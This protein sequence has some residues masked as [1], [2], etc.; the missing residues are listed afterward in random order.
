MYPV[1]FKRLIISA[2]ILCSLLII[3]NMAHA[4]T[5][6]DDF[7][8]QIR[9]RLEASGI[10]VSIVIGDELIYASEALPLF[11]ER[12]GYLP[13]WISE[14]KIKKETD[15]LISAIDGAA[16]E[17]LDPR[18]YHITGIRS[19]LKSLRSRMK[20]EKAEKEKKLLE[21]ELLC[22]DAFLIYS[23]HLLRGK[24]NPRSID[25]E[26]HANLREMD[27]VEF[28]EKTIM[29]GKIRKALQTLLPNNAGYKKLKSALRK[30]RSL[31]REGSWPVIPEGQTLQLGDQ[32]ARITKL[33]ERLIVTDDLPM[34]E[35]NNPD[36]FDSAVY[37]AVTKFQARHGLDIDGKVGP[38]TLA[39]LNV[40]VEIRIQQIKLNLER[41]RWLPEK[42][43]EKYII[44]NIAN[45]ELDYFEGDNLKLKMRA[46][47]GKPY[48][49]TPVF[50]DSVTYIVLN[51][52][53]H[54]PPSIAVS[55]ILPAA[56]KNPNYLKEN[57][58]RVFEGWGSDAIEIDA[59]TI[60]WAEMSK[61]NFKY[62]LRQDP[63]SRNALGRIKFMFPNEFNVYLHDTPS[64]DLFSKSMRD[65][66]SGCI[67][68]ERPLE[69]A[70]ILLRQNSSWDLER[71]Q[72]AIQKDS[73]ETLLLKEKMPIHILYWT[74]WAGED[75]TINFRKDLY[76]RD[77]AL[78][79][80]LEEK[81]QIQI[82]SNGQ[83]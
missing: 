82:E 18:D 2:I 71:L 24:V 51:P 53:W 50:S 60:N 43:G 80:A 13:A 27:M 55:D 79:S 61:S 64:R 45:Y 68:I 9:N 57:G 15:S 81:A 67:R 62:R 1:S 39:A 6:N 73:E 48:R 42:L 63:G 58:F 7:Q 3:E 38:V 12:R 36:Y 52:Y 21:L 25:S 46:I 59:S 54:V 41:W 37:F 40:P 14:G 83:E 11:Y 20:F 47:V 78:I 49:R 75:G 35:Y 70:D 26:W 44:V 10:P 29:S 17:G 4:G 16:T 34:I 33:R 77:D 30:Y 5:F 56:K 31:R 19:I 69:L 72:T 22:T 28:I 74:T 76:K 32:G 23:T 8:E 66:S 65:F